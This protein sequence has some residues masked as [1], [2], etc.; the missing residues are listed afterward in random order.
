MNGL[1]MATCDNAPPP[2]GGAPEWV[3]LFP[4]GHMVARDGR[5]FD[6]ADPAAVI[7]AFENNGA[8]LPIDYEHQ[9]DKPE[10][11]LKGPIPAAG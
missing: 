6:L 5:Q 8:D 3:R 9:A 7:A 11:K 4:N 1:K 2:D 10:A